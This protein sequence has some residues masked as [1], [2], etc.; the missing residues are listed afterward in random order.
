MHIIALIAVSAQNNVFEL[1]EQLNK[2]TT[3]T[4]LPT[5]LIQNYTRCI[6]LSKQRRKCGTR[7]FL[8]PDVL[9]NPL[10]FD[11]CCFVFFAVDITPGES[12]LKID[13]FGANLVLKVH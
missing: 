6:K 10:L 5:T 7:Y 2:E 9:A 3:P 13:I 12:A 8:K 11:C 1:S 4:F